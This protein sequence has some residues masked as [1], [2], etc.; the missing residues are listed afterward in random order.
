M[1]PSHESVQIG[2]Q[3]LSLNYPH[4]LRTQIYHDI[5]CIYHA[6]KWCYCDLYSYSFYTSLQIENQMQCH[7]CFMFGCRVQKRRFAHFKQL[8]RTQHSTLR[9]LWSTHWIV[10]S[11]EGLSYTLLMHYFLRNWVL[12]T[13]KDTS[14]IIAKPCIHPFSPAAFIATGLSE[15]RRKMCSGCRHV[16]NLSEICKLFAVCVDRRGCNPVKPWSTLDAEWTRSEQ[17]ASR[18]CVFSKPSWPI[19]YLTRCCCMYLVMI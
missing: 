6:Y 5:F 1:I 15:A 7:C 13:A 12:P 19:C 17:H 16:K 18:L 11:Q 10:S 4:I 3:L 2:T 8:S 9:S 14:E